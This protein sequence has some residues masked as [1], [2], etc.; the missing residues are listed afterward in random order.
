MFIFR[1]AR[2]PK[3]SFPTLI[4]NPISINNRLIREFPPEFIPHIIT[5]QEW[6]RGFIVFCI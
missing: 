3:L 1:Q 2:C 5:G 6:Q 4:R